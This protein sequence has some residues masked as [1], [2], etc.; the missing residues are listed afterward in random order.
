[1]AYDLITV[2]RVSM[3]LFSLQIG[4]PFSEI[5]SFDTS[6]GGSPVNIA[7]GVSRLGLQTATLTAVGAD[8]VGDFVLNF[9][10]KQGVD[11]QLIARNADARTGLAV[12]GIEPPDRFP[13][14]FYRENPADIHLSIDDAMA[15][16]I[17]ES[18][19]LLLSGT[20]LSRGDCRDATRY[21]AEIAAAAPTVTYLDLDLRPDQ[22][23][24]PRAYG[25]NLRSLLP[26]VDVIIGTEE[27]FYAALAPNPEPIMAK[28]ATT[29]AMKAELDTLIGGVRQRQPSATLVLKRGAEGV[30]IY[31]AAGVEDVAGYPVEVVNT[32]GAGD[33]FAS[34][35]IYGRVQGWDWR[36]AGSFGN[37]CGALVVTRHGCSK[38]MPYQEEVQTFLANRTGA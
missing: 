32:V 14:V 2:G 8:P 17:A 29:D 6:V 33:A 18:R 30:R 34:G 22:W 7:I 28:A 24:H 3:D 9:L 19:G 21:A 12:L 36:K 1:M 4:A 37:A 16:P 15:A 35:L 11:T 20:A 31:H 25:V 38:A 13:L 27:E 23:R 5:E 26:W 10:Q